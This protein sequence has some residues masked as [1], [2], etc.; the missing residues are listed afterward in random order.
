MKDAKVIKKK[1]LGLQGYSMG[2]RG[3]LDTIQDITTQQED[4]LITSAQQCAPDCM[5]DFGQAIEPFCSQ[6]QFNMLS[7]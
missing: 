4:H 7:N 2:S 6:F 1:G 5:C 3:R